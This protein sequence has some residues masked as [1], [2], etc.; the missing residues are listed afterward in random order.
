M[1]ELVRSLSLR[2]GG[3][4]RP[5]GETAAPAQD[6]WPT[7]R[8][9]RGA[10][11]RAMG[12]RAPRI[13]LPHGPVNASNALVWMDLEMTGLDPDRERIIEIAV[14]V[15]DAQL[16]ITAEGPDLVIHQPESLLSQMDQ[17]NQ[18]H[19]AASG[20]IERVRASEVTEAQAEEQVLAFLREHVAERAVP[21][22]G[23]S[24]H[25]DRR[26]LRRYMPSVDAY[27]HYRNVD[28]STIKEL[29]RRWYPAVLA[30]APE[31]KGAHRALDDIRDS[32][33]ELRY[34]RTQVFR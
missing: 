7:S 20:L 18:T 19:H 8:S 29:V 16:E 14:L 25:Q 11:T 10:A 21:L 1:L 3:P 32:I 17:W 6:A 31:K 2:L 5:A 28:V 27:L 34:Y 33:A 9:S 26:F 12:R 22:A 24:I 4:D 13:V 30:G 15:T 23:N